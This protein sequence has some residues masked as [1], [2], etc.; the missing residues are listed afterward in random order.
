VGWVDIHTHFD[1]Q[2]T[3]DPDL[4]LSGLYCATTA[5]M[6]NCG[7]GFAPVSTSG[8]ER[9]TLDTAEAYALRDRGRLAPGFLAD[10]NVIDLVTL[11]LVVQAHIVRIARQP[12]RA[13]TR[14]R[15]TREI[16]WISIPQVAPPRRQ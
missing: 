9:Q 1:A 10:I 6:G 7:V 2:A 3:W 12:K 11:S 16:Q 14:Q 4:T 13:V 15:S 8:R 5:I